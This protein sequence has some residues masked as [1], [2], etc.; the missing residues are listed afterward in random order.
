LI[1]LEPRTGVDLAQ[2]LSGFSSSATIAVLGI[3]AI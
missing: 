1:V 3:H 2:G